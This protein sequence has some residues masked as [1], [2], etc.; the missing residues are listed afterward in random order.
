MYQLRVTI[1]TPITPIA[2]NDREK[3]LTRDGIDD[4]DTVTRISWPLL[5]EVEY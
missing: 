3:R 2:K 1:S 4:M 5:N